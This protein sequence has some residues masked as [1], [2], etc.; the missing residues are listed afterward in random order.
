[1]NIL[2][3][4]GTLGNPTGNWFPW[5]ATELEKQGHRT[6]TPQLPTPEGQTLPNWIHIIDTAINTL[7]GPSN[8]IGIVA[9]SMA[10][11]AVCHYLTTIYSPINSCF[12]VSGFSQRLPSTPQPYPTLNNPFIDQPLEWEKVKRNCNKFICFAGDNDPYV[13]L[14]TANNF[15]EHLATRLIVIPQG[16]HLNASSGYIQFPLLLD[17]IA[18]TCKS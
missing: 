17:T 1:M 5:L 16:G 7:G 9:H 12:F 13:P 2:I 15:A 11:L 8:D 10:P 4:H 18:V 14:N 3:L 6:L